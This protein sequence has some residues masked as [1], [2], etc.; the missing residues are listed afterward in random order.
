MASGADQKNPS[1]NRGNNQPQRNQFAESIIGRVLR[2]IEEANQRGN[3]E[4]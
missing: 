1:G 3:T 2:Q 4:N